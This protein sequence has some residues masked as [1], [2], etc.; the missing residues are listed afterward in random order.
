MCITRTSNLRYNENIYSSKSFKFHM[1]SE[2]IDIYANKK[3]NNYDKIDFFKLSVYNSTSLQFLK[4][5]IC[6]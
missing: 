2:K 3:K 5:N 4:E 1:Q 6:D